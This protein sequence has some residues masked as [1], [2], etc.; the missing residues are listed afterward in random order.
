LQP[1]Y[2]D[3]D[4]EIEGVTSGALDGLVPSKGML[5][6]VQL[7]P[8]GEPLPAALFAKLLLSQFGS[9]G[10]PIDCGIDVAASGQAMRISR[11]DVS[12]SADASGNPI[13]VGSARGSVT[14]PKDGSWSVVQ[15]DQGTGEVTPL[16]P[17][18]PVPVVR[19][20]ILNVAVGTTDTTAA[21]LVR[22][23]NPADIVAALTATSRNFGLLDRHAEGPVPAA[24]V[25]PG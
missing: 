19:R 4:V 22:L 23:A 3:A 2:F 9:L 17:Q 25:P 16:D 13:F 14:L 10:G 21:D 5:G 18:V 15:H 12:P 6:Y 8:R 1:V 11:A 20:G 7:A 24:G